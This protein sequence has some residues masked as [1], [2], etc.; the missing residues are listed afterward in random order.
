VALTYGYT[1]TKSIGVMTLVES[2]ELVEC[3]DHLIY[4][5]GIREI[6]SPYK[7]KVDYI[8]VSDFHELKIIAETLKKPLFYDVYYYYVILDNYI[9]YRTKRYDKIYR[10]YD[11]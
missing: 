11:I 9:T 6:R 5:I 1:K 8:E 3:R 2:S 7:E 10:T 4:P